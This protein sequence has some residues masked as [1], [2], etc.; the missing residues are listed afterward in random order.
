M[1]SHTYPDFYWSIFRV[2]N[3]IIPAFAGTCIS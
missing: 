1:F 3:R 2:E